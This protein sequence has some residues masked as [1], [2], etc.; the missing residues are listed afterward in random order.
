MCCLHRASPSHSV[1]E[2]ED[3]LDR[4]RA[5]AGS[6]SALSQNAIGKVVTEGKH[7]GEPYVYRVVL[8]GGPCGGKSSSLEHFTKKLTALGFDSAA[9]FRHSL[10][11]I[12]TIVVYT[13]PEVPTILMNGGCRFPG[14]GTLRLTL[15]LDGAAESHCYPYTNTTVYPGTSND[16]QLFA[17][18]SALLQFQLQA[19]R[20]FLR[21]ASS[22]L[23]P[24][25][26]VMDRSICDIKAYM[27]A[28]L[29]QKLL[30]HHSLTE[31]YINKRYD[32]ILHLVTAADGAEKYYT[33]AN[34]TARKETAEQ[35]RE[36][37]KKL[38]NAYT[39]AKANGTFAR[40][41]NTTDFEKKVARATAAVMRMLESDVVAA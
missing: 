32:L 16:D 18:E 41:D 7:A 33:C 22:T 34:N 25:V 35:A 3:L 15:L 12:P 28:T 14:T 38:E 36:L 19:E 1:P 23:R 2:R 31:E 37:D 27:S 17:F 13:V 24:A 39:G 9:T 30:E 29:W 40:I 26:V 21:I 20:S 8:T 4:G 10:L 6:S 5:V 11:L